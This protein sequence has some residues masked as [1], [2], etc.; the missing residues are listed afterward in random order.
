MKKQAVRVNLWERMAFAKRAQKERMAAMKENVEDEGEK[1]VEVRKLDYDPSAE[2][3][4]CSKPKGYVW[5]HRRKRYAK[6]QAKGA[7]TMQ[8][9]DIKVPG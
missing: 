7:P 3:P 4:H 6:F 8:I 9:N 2:Y 5:K 1:K